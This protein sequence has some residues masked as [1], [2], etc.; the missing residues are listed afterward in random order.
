ME[1]GRQKGRGLH[2]P[3]AWHSRPGAD[4]RRG[5]EKRNRLD[6][7]AK[8]DKRAGDL[9]RDVRKQRKETRF[10][11]WAARCGR[12]GQNDGAECSKSTD[13]VLHTKS[14]GWSGRS[15]PRRNYKFDFRQFKQRTDKTQTAVIHRENGIK[16]WKT[17]EPKRKRRVW[18][19]TGRD[20]PQAEGWAT[21]QWN[22]VGSLNGGRLLLVFDYSEHSIQCGG[23]VSAGWSQHQD[24]E[25]QQFGDWLGGTHE[26]TRSNM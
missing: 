18:A 3:E 15:D 16:S 20:S 19:E 21:V 23:L 8:T 2:T 22:N 4:E 17:K 6:F 13:L 24:D 7:T 5:R 11:P 12:N 9:E 10:D 14:A 1:S 25:H 26:P